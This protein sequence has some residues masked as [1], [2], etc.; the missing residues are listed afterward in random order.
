MSRSK[1]I[2]TILL[3]LKTITISAQEINVTGAIKD[4]LANLTLQGA[5]V[6][7]KGME[8]VPFSKIILTDKEGIFKLALPKPGF[9]TIGV[10]FIGYK[11]HTQDT[12]LFDESHLSAPTILMLPDHTNLQAVTVT[13]KKPFIVMGTN[14]ITLNVAQSPIAAGSNAY[15]VIKKAPGVVEQNDD[16]SFKGKSTRILINGRPSNL[17][18]EDLK[19][20][21][22]NMQASNIERIEILLN[23]SA[24]YDAQGGAVIN[25]ILAKNKLYGTNYVLTTGIGT[26]KYV[27]ENTGLDVNYRNKNMNLYGGYSFE[28]NQ[29]YYQTNSIRYLTAIQLK[30]D[31]DDVRKRNNNGYKLGLDYDINGKK[32]IGFLLNGY[33]N[34]RDR[35]VDN[36]SILHYD[37]NVFD[38]TS[39]VHTT[40][41]S[42]IK[43][44][45]LNIYYKAT[46]D[47][48]GKEL[49][50]NADYMHYGKQW[51]DDFTNNYYDAK[52]QQYTTPDYL[53][54]NSPAKIKVY[55]FT[56]DYVQP[57]K[58]GSLEIGVKTSY[59]ITDND[60]FW[61][62]NNGTGWLTDQGKTNHFIYKENVNA[63]YGNYTRTIK[64]WNIVTGL[65]VEQTNTISNSITASQLNKNSY[66]DFFPNIS[67]GYTK[68]DNNVFGLSYRKSINRFGFD[69][70]NPFIIYENR[71]A[72]SQGNPNIKPE[73]YHTAEVSYTYKQ[74]YSITLDYMHGIKTLGEIY[75]AG[76]N[77]TTI[78]SYANYN[79]SNI[80][81]VSFSAN[82][83]LTKN[84][85]ISLNPMYGYMSLKNGVQNVSSGTN[86]KR[87]VS[88]VSCNNTFSFNK[89]WVA[90]LS[91]MYIGPFQYGSYTTKTMFS[92]DIGIS[93]TILKNKGN[94]KLSVSDI[95]NTLSYNKELN[96][97]GILTDLKNKPESRFI[98]VAFK[99]KFGNKNIKEKNQRESK[100]NDLKNRIQ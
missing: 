54:D 79:T 18:G 5:E 34:Y 52:G 63:V 67:V 43:N 82:K 60:V 95:F 56:A 93:K 40:G 25:I 13:T 8:T 99:Y 72:Y 100:M 24:K 92:T 45:S 44:P 20:M 90:E 22:T 28:H 38:S 59:T 7:I 91:V 4:S 51:N 74:A 84:W 94:L 21:L 17:S 11:A 65:R 39:M 19:T 66:V 88:Q 3:F 75:L 58:K 71:Y 9:Y 36:T 15:D 57:T 61:Q 89:D 16:L 73:I 33:V 1:A 96:Y 32:S 41:K 83:S 77:N 86:K 70:V 2:I 49:T 50:L 14:I 37:K 64:K 12:V 80:F 87:W 68:N 98:N 81:Y 29:Q 76:A 55:S 6:T 42:I 23:P 31:E 30:A 53:K 47:T 10:T 69:V 26:G 35:K 78:S 85:D 48:T 46:L 62:S 27:S 97:A